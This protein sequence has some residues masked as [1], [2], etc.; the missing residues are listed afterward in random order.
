M[1]MD[2]I[3]LFAALGNGALVLC[4]YMTAWGAPALDIAL[5]ELTLA[6]GAAVSTW[7]ALGG[8]RRRRA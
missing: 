8:L 4:L 7:Y 2:R 3:Q 6:A 5:L 1:T